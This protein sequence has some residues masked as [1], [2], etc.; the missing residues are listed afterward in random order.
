[1]RPEHNLRRHV[2]RRPTLYDRA[3]GSWER[4]GPRW[5]L[6]LALALLVALA[7]TTAA[8]DDP[9]FYEPTEQVP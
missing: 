6:R 7:L 2:V 1:V 8:L 9:E 4:L 3:L 5:H